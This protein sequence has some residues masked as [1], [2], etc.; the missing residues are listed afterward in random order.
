[1]IYNLI[2]I[3]RFDFDEVQNN[4]LQKVRLFPSNYKFQRII[5]WDIKSDDADKELVS[6]DYHGNTIQLFRKVSD[7]LFI[8]IQSTGEVE[9]IDN[10][11]IVGEHDNLIPLELYKNETKLTYAGNRVK[12]FFKKFKNEINKNHKIDDV[13][14]L[15]K[16]SYFVK[17]N[18]KYLKKRYSFNDDS[19]KISIEK[20]ASPII[21]GDYT[22]I[23]W[24]IENMIKNS[25][26]SI[27]IDKRI[28]KVIIDENDKSGI[29]FIEDNGKGIERHNWNNIFKPGFTTKLRGWG[30]GL[31]LVKRIIEE[32]H[33]GKISVFKSQNNK[34]TTFK[35]ILNKK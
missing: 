9:V 33:Q 11:G 8:E 14:L 19:L 34:G 7:K 35:I 18:I 16:L 31:S 20:I 24:A 5:K 22:L 3:T 2:H 1:M 29:I 32:L 15:H 4:V 10:D 6:K 12:K 17:E 13:Q 23:G 28:I 27:E 25:I 26:D 30:I 21:V